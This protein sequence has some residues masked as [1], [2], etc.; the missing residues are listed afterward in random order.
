[1]SVVNS[2]MTPV[3]ECLESSNDDARAIH[4]GI[5]RLHLEVTAEAFKLA[6]RNHAAG[7]AVIT[8]DAGD[9]PVGLTVTS[10]FS[11]SVTPNLLAFSVSEHSSSTPAILKA[12]TVVVHL[13]AADQLHIAKLC[14]TSGID[15]FA[16]L[17][18]WR[19]LPTGEPH[20]PSAS[21]WIRARILNRIDAGRSTVMI[22]EAVQT[23]HLAAKD[24]AT[25]VKDSLPLIFHNR[26]WH[27]LSEQSRIDR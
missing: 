21:V 5:P 25:T 11:I 2:E 6:F 17:S 3:D 18:M 24:S 16:D 1:M 12:D 10:V 23:K 13:L 7:V 15:R 19:K 26:T 9:G 8:A 4:R 22:A 27:S 14:A 20:F